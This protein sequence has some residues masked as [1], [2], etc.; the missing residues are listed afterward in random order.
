MR[1]AGVR[2]MA[3]RQVS[4]SYLEDIDTLFV[5]FELKAGFYDLISE[6][7]DR[8]WARY[9]E[10]GKVIGFMIDGLKDLKD[11]RGF[12]LSDI[13]REEAMLQAEPLPKS[14]RAKDW[15]AHMSQAD[16]IRQY[17]AKRYIEPARREGCN[18][19]SIRAGDVH[20]AMELANRMPAVCSAMGTKKFQDMANVK[21][22]SITGPNQGST[23]TFNY[24]IL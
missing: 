16:D 1:R 5:H 18:V 17:V 15:T 13:T 11:L 24:R 2:D 19:V 7:D 4:V 14:Q 10:N 23:T 12:E 20:K 9:D 21:V 3:K 6:D 8:I 22:E